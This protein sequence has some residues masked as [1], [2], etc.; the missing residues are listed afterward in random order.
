MIVH[1]RITL[2]LLFMS[3]LMFAN[4]KIVIPDL[5]DIEKGEA[6]LCKEDGITIGAMPWRS[7]QLI[8]N[9]QKKFLETKYGC[10]VEIVTQTTNITMANIVYDRVDVVNEVWI[11]SA[12]NEFRRSIADGSIHNI[13][14]IYG[15]G[16]EGWWVP[17]YT[18]RAFPR[19]NSVHDLKVHSNIFYA[20][21]VDNKPYFL[22]C[23]KGWGCYVVNNNLL[24]AYGLSN[25][26]NIK[27]PKNGSDFESQLIELYN[28]KKH[29]VTYYW[30][31]TPLISKIG[32]VPLQMDEFNS[33]GH[34]CNLDFQCFTPHA[35][36]FP[37]SVIIKVVSDSFYKTFP[38]I[39]K[40][41]KRMFFSV[42]TVNDII[43]WGYDNEAS[44]DEMVD[45]AL[46]KYNNKWQD[47]MLQ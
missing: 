16:Y 36:S 1:L 25:T 19:L 45:Y 40:D 44:A 30:S 22:N 11:N 38:E 33:Q 27:S 20:D 7:N 15:G 23:P 18:K 34:D 31:P 5:N 2:I 28:Q 46:M 21:P 41:L 13:G 4:E 3:N 8:A 9:L 43:T 17:D 10:D 47:F 39:T 14:R 37:Q 24:A 32:L 29:F 35:G 26:F 42:N 6:I 12:S